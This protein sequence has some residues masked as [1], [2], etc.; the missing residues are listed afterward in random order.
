MS[1]APVDDPRSP[2]RGDPAVTREAVDAR[3]RELAAKH[4]TLAALER[5]LESAR[6]RRAELVD[7][8]GEGVDFV[9][10][11][12]APLVGAIVGNLLAA[13]AL[14]FSYVSLIFLERWTFAVTIAALAMTA[15]FEILAARPGAGGSARALLRRATRLVALVAVLALAAGAIRAL[16]G[17]HRIHF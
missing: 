11:P 15:S 14:W 16:T 7:L 6:D 13:T 2:L 4:E 5:S 1:A 10:L 17:G 8:L 12:L 9:P 3:E